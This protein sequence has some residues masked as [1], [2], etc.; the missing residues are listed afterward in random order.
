MGRHKAKCGR[1]SETMTWGLR[2]D[3]PTNFQLAIE[4]ITSASDGAKVDGFAGVSFEFLSEIEDVTID[5]VRSR[6][7]LVAECFP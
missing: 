3:I 4:P 1:V 5:C 7:V 2:A 6:I